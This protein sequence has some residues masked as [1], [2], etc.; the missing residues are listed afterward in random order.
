MLT[1]HGAHFKCPWSRLTLATGFEGEATRL[2]TVATEVA[3]RPGSYYLDHV[4]DNKHI[5]AM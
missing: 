3:Q 2:A 5:I 1:E 4:E